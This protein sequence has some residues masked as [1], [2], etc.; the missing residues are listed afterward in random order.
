MSTMPSRDANNHLPRK[1]HHRRYSYP[2][3]LEL[4]DIST[5]HVP[6]PDIDDDP[7]AHFVSPSQEDDYEPTLDAL[8]S[9]AGIVGSHPSIS[10]SSE[11]AYK[12]R[13][14]IAR[15]WARFIR[16]HYAHQ[17]SPKSTEKSDIKVG[18]EEAAKHKRKK[19]D[20]SKSSSASKHEPTTGQV[21]QFFSKPAAT[22]K[23]DPP[24]R[25]PH[26]RSR[27]TWHAPPDD[28][29]S[30]TEENENFE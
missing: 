25:I 1:H 18:K 17:E 3:S 8:A 2:P 29:Y 13:T 9:S 27:H 14:S 6:L 23:K 10:K 28:L 19:H 4:I 26:K 15:K 11:K 30:I 21:Q 7:F 22:T 24:P 12:F 5:I 16:R 20:S